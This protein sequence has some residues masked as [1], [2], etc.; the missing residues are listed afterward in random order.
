LAKH[1]SY[2]ARRETFAERGERAASERRAS[3]RC[4]EFFMMLSNPRK[5]PLSM[6]VACPVAFAHN[7]FR[8][9]GADNHRVP[10]VQ[11]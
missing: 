7:I 4:A 3:L 9:A 5:R 2:D 10:L 1:F 11:L 6:R 8:L